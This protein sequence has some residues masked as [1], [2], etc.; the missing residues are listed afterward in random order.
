MAKQAGLGDNCYVDGFDVSGD[1]GS[2]QRVS[3]SMTTQDTTAINKSAMERIGLLHDGGIDYGAFWNPGIAADTAHSVH[4]T[5]PT[6]DRVVTYCRGT[7][8]GAHA[9]SLVGK[10]VN[11]D[12]TRGGDG[13]FTFSLNALGNAYGLDWGQLLTAGKLTQ[14]AAANGATVDLGSEIISYSFG[15][16]AYLHVFA[17]TGT[18]ITVKVQDSADSS[19]WADI[20][21]A[22]FVAATA[23]G[24]QRI[25]AGATSTATVRRYVRLVST[26]TFSN[27]VFAV[28][29][30]RYENAGH[31]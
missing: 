19:A 27:A 18:S 17:F 28:N 14:G 10:Q 25:S 11:Y 5:L 23:V 6:T 30:V 20:T 13:S 9:A 4:R 24:S 7:A 21:S 1:I 3:G 16:A 22:T 29:F 8:L 26:G 31:A 15:W 2:L 12:G